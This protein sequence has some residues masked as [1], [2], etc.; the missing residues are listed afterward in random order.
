MINLVKEKL[1]QLFES[2]KKTLCFEQTACSN[3]NLNVIFIKGST[4]NAHNIDGKIVIKDNQPYV[5]NNGSLLETDWESVQIMAL[6]QSE[7]TYLWINKINKT[8]WQNYVHKN[9][10]NK[11]FLEEIYLFPK[12]NQKQRELYYC[13]KLVFDLKTEKI[14]ICHSVTYGTTGHGLPVNPDFIESY[15]EVSMNEIFEIITGKDKSEIQNRICKSFYSHKI[16]KFDFYQGC[17]DIFIEE[18]RKLK[19]NWQKTVSEIKPLFST[20][21]SNIIPGLNLAK[22]PINLKAECAL[23]IGFIPDEHYASINIDLLTGQPYYSCNWIA[24]MGPGMNN[25]L[26]D[27]YQYPISWNDFKRCAK[28]SSYDAYEF[29]KDINSKNW[30]EFINSDWIRLDLW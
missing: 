19:D 12:Q 16:L 22:Y 29:F 25:Y 20:N 18:Q 23:A 27:Y 10:I 30:K 21:T 9:I 4:E 13:D 15:I 26:T 6:E 2:K 8:N 7:S 14:Y 1:E 5:I 24:G 3:K 17:S 11:H 28:K